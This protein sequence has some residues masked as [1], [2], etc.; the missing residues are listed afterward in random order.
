M[1]SSVVPVPAQPW[2]GTGVTP[3]R[4]W[5]HDF[6]LSARSGWSSPKTRPK[7][8]TTYRC[9]SEI[10]EHVNHCK[11][12]S[13]G[14]WWVNDLPAKKNHCFGSTILEDYSIIQLYYQLSRSRT[15]QKRERRRPKSQQVRWQAAVLSSLSLA[16]IPRSGKSRS[17][18]GSSLG[19]ENLGNPRFLLCRSQL[20]FGL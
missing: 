14:H 20:S 19:F 18:N 11:G 1:I 8:Q 13:M 12:K 2:R 17:H 5:Y 7:M 16:K 10:R 4:R 9:Q 6:R 15:R 3:Q